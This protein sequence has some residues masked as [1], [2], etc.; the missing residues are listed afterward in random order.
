MSRSEEHEP[1]IPLALYRETDSN[2][3]DLHQGSA[4]YR[5]RTRSTSMTQGGRVFGSV[6]M[7]TEGTTPPTAPCIMVVFGATGDLCRRLL[8]P[9]LYNL[10][11]DGLLSERFAVLGTARRSICS[12]EYRA[13]IGSK[14]QGIEHYP[15]NDVVLAH[16]D[17][18]QW[19][20]I[21]R[22]SSQR[23]VPLAS[24]EFDIPCHV[25][26]TSISVIYCFA[27]P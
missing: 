1:R 16:Q 4:G 6:R 14:N 24:T 7:K 9:A 20:R 3:I 5:H 27:A 13:L 2:L 22:E 23:L 21:F 18:L 25:S 26:S 19:R 12:E 11:C 17:P 8:M 15:P 10:V